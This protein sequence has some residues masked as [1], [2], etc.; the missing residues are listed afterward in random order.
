MKKIKATLVWFVKVEVE[1]DSNKD[2]N[3][4]LREDLCDAAREKL[5]QGSDN[6][7]GPFVFDCD[8]HSVEDLIC[9]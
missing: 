6:V 9:R 7:S 1:V 2:Q 3:L 5:L 4:D 8:D